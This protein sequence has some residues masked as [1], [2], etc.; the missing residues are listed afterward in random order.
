MAFCVMVKGP[1]RG[2]KCDFWARIKIKKLTIRQVA[3]HMVKTISECEGGSGIDL[4]E[5]IKQYWIE[6]G[7]TDMQVLCDEEPDLCSKMKLVEKQVRML[8]S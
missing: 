1:C 4:G 2:S 8:L 6:I 3:D 5:A 7:V